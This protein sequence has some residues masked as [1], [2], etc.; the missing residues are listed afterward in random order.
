MQFT[1][2]PH[3]L[4]S[5][6]SK[7]IGDESPH[8]S[9][10]DTSSSLISERDAAAAV[11]TAADGDDEDDDLDSGDLDASVVRAAPMCA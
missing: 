5:N 4:L 7:V 10:G 3:L 9:R 2:S 6:S 8:F 1:H 11:A